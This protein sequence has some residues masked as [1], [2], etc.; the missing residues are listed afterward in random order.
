MK[1]VSSSSVKSA[2][3]PTAKLL[4]LDIQYGSKALEERWSPLLT[5]AKIRKWMLAGLQEPASITLRLVGTAEGRK[6]NREFREKDYATNILTF[7][8]PTPDA[9]LEADLVICMPVVLREAREQKKTFDHHFI[10]LLIHGLL[11][12]QGFDH[13][14]DIEAQ[15]ME[16]LEIA[17]LSQLKIQNPYD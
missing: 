8:Y 4:S 3:P 1:K 12:A 2:T 6:L 14:D 5:R 10:H 13:E 7:A 9:T 15:A 11:H 17:M 16:S